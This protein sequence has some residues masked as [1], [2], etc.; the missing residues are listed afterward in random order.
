[1][2]PTLTLYIYVHS[3]LCASWLIKRPSIN[4]SKDNTDFCPRTTSDHHDA[5]IVNDVQASRRIMLSA[6]PVQV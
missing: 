5:H 6:E 4:P 2:K 1:M 3:L